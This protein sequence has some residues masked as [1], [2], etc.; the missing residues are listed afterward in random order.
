MSVSPRN[1]SAAGTEGM[2]DAPRYRS[3]DVF[4]TI[5]QQVQ[6][7]EIGRNEGHEMDGNSTEEPEE[8]R[9]GNEKVVETIESLCMNCQQN[10]SVI[11]QLNPR[12]QI[13]SCS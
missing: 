9:W 10:V 3:Q 1:D 8:Y 12:H 6:N 11:A 2:A 5:G 7:L 13:G 4:D